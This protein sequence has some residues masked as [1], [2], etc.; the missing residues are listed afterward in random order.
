M[1]ILDEN[2]EK[3][4]EDFEDFIEIMMPNSTID[5]YQKAR[6]G[7]LDWFMSDFFDKNKLNL[8][9]AKK[10]TV[11]TYAVFSGN[12]NLVEYLIKIGADCSLRDYRGHNAVEW[13]ISERS[14]AIFQKS[15]SMEILKYNNLISLIDKKIYKKF[16]DDLDF[17]PFEDFITMK[18]K[19][20]EMTLTITCP[21]HSF[22]ED[23]IKIYNPN[24]GRKMRVIVPNNI[25]P[26]M[27]FEIYMPS[28]VRIFGIKK[29]KTE[30]SL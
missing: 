17:K 19:Q 13:I 16:F 1:E 6:R 21:E 20:L 30:A 10:R 2:P 8:I 3:K 11:L 14:H 4:N 27:K 15:G 12:E 29:G 24:T 23:I 22:F 5:M 18:T 25:E 7:D 9:D 28:V 26:G